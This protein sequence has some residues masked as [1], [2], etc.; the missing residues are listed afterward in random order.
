MWF[1]C[2]MNKSKLLVINFLIKLYALRNIFNLEESLA[3]CTGSKLYESIPQAHMPA[4]TKNLVL[5]ISLLLKGKTVWKN[6]LNAL[7]A[8]H[9]NTHNVKYWRKPAIT[10]QP[11]RF[12]LLSM[13][14]RKKMRR[15]ISATEK[16]IKILDERRARSFLK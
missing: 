5:S 7:T 10:W 12:S 9:A 6:K 11:T 3:Q 8:I 1:I 4:N 13:P 14:A 15:N 2:K 16:Q